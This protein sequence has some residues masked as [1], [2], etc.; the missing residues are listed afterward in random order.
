VDRSDPAY[1]GQA[2]YS[3]LLLVLYDPIA[4]DVVSWLVWRVPA[5]Q[6]QSPLGGVLPLPGGLDSCVNPGGR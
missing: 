5:I 2:D 1:R 6:S 4:I 3:P